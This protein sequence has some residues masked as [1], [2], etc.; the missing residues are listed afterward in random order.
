MN[1][2]EIETFPMAKTII[3][4]DWEYNITYSASDY[5]SINLIPEED[6]LGKLPVFSIDMATKISSKFADFFYCLIFIGAG[7]VL[8]WSFFRRNSQLKNAYKYMTRDF[9]KRPEKLQPSLN[10][11]CGFH[12][13]LGNIEGIMLG[14]SIIFFRI[15]VSNWCKK[16]LN[17]S[18]FHTEEEKQQLS[19]F[20][21][22]SDVGLSDLVPNLRYVL[23]GLGFF[24]S[25]GI[26]FS[27]NVAALAPFLLSVA[28][29]YLFLNLGSTLYL[30]RDSRKDQI[31]ILVI[32]AVVFLVL[33]L[34]NIIDTLRL[35]T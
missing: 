1:F 20:I 21:K 13:E 23:V 2:Y 31:W 35:I 34:P 30:L 11:L 19:K 12:N 8:S 28:A 18:D 14:L 25:V 27:W 15:S 24:A 32:L 33:L 7:L 4:Y 6:N 16:H 29:V 9:P 10:L 3:T 22:E 17:N 5:Y 26:S